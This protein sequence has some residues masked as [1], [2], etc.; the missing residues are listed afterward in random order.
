[1]GDRL[2]VLSAA[3]DPGSKITLG[4]VGLDATTGRVRSRT[5]LAEFRDV[6]RGQ[7]P[8]QAAVAED[9]IVAAVGGCVLCCDT[10]GRVH[11]VR[12]QV[13]IPPLSSEYW[14]GREWIDQAFSPPL[15]EEG[16]VF[17]TQP[18]VWAIEC[19]AL[20][21]GR[22]RWRQALGGLVRLLG[23]T[24]GRLVAETTDGLVGLDSESGRL[25]WSLEVRDRLE[26][27]L[28]GPQGVE[29]LPKSPYPSVLTIYLGR[30]K[31]DKAPRPI[32]LEWIDPQTG[33]RLGR[34]TLKMPVAIPAATPGPAPP[35]A[36]SW[37]KP[38]VAAEGRVWGFSASLKE[39]AQR[40]IVELVRI[41]EPEEG[42]EG[43]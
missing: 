38:V 2:F 43:Q 28:C 40:D 18:G 34:S 13:W 9:R 37:L 30:K 24:R 33:R 20:E 32:L 16:W 25:V 21:S 29:Q 1:V 8:C 15:V 41:G 10:A 39:P 22:L 36:E 27:I 31:D 19:M 5:T 14:N 11:W 26:T 6:W 35:P 17:A 42:P 23:C 4:L 7:L 12:R 3:A